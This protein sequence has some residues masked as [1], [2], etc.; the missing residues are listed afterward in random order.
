MTIPFPL[1]QTTD[2]TLIANRLSCRELC[3]GA[4]VWLLGEAAV[5]GP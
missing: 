5:Q 1:I 3:M 2:S 4:L